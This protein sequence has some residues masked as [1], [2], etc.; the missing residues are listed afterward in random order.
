MN[1][2]KHAGFTLTELMI[3]IAIIGILA[4]IA[5]PSFQATIARNQLKEAI[6]G[7]QSDLMFARSQS[8]KNSINIH[9]SLKKTTSSWCYGIND[10]ATACNCSTSGD[11]AI[12]SVDGSQ[13][14]SIS[15]DADDDTTFNFRRGTATAM[16]STLSN[17]LYEA[18]VQVSN[19]GRI[20]ICSPTS[21][22]ALG[23]YNAC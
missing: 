6:E 15:L 10:S 17:T 3:T 9:A 4:S 7:L 16:G 8:I 14:Q 5:V 13:F 22:K 19:R 11:C 1:Q 20:T 2:K 18:R 21:T 12:K 23:E